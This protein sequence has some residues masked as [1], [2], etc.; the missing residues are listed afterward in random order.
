[1]NDSLSFTAAMLGAAV[2]QV[3]DK[4]PIIDNVT[5]TETMAS[6]LISLVVGVVSMFLSRLLNNLF[7]KS[8][9]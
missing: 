2:V 3:A 4:M 6:G 1:M 7:K 8:Q 9:K 5:T